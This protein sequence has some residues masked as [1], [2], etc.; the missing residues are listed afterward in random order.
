DAVRIISA[1]GFYI[2]N[3]RTQNPDE[4]LVQGLH[5]L[6]NDVSLLRVGKK[7]YWIVKWLK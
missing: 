3:N 4:V 5:M 7:N 2:N 6:H 1:G